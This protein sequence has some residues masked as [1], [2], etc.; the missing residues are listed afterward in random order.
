[1]HTKFRIVNDCRVV[2][3]LVWLVPPVSLTTYEYHLSTF[4]LVQIQNHLQGRSSVTRPSVLKECAS[5]PIGHGLLN[6]IP[7]Q[8][9]GT[10]ANGLFLSK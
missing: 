2:V 5:F 3:V 4:H 8:T 10:L 9:L 6:Y 7:S 1:M